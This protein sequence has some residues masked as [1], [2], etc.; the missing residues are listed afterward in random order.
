LVPPH[1]LV[2]KLTLPAAQRPRHGA[3]PAAAAC[4]PLLVPLLLLLLLPS[5]LLSLCMLLTAA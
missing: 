1:G 4:C 3:L 2:C 5:L